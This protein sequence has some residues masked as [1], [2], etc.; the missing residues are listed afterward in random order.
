MPNPAAFAKDRKFWVR[1][2]WGSVIALISGLGTL[3]FVILMNLGLSVVWGWLDP[4][5]MEAFSGTWPILVIMT[6][7]G[8][9]VGLLHHFTNAKE[10][11]VFEAIQSGYLDPKP[12]PASLAVSLVSLIGGFSVGPEVPSGMWAGGF[13]TW[14]SERRD[15]S[16]E[17]RESNVSS[18]VVSAY[19]GLFTSP[20]AFVM[21]R[22]ELPHRQ[23][24]RFFGVLVIATVSATL[25]FA[26]FYA[27]AGDEYAD[28][29][30]LLDLPSYTLELW[31]LFVALALSVLGAA[32]A[33]V[34]GVTLGT[35]KRFAAP[36]ERR[37]ILRGAGV[38][39][40]LGLLGMALPLT[41]FLGSEGLV[42]VTEK[43]A[44]MGLAVVLAL[45]FAKILATAGALST[46]FIGGPIF[47]L[48]F[49]GGAA[50]TAINLMFP[51]IPLALAVGCT[52]AA[53]TAA[54]LPAPFMITI[55]VLLVTGI[56]ATEGIPVLLAAMVAHGIV[57]G[58]G[59]LP[60]PPAAGN[61]G[62]SSAQSTSVG[63]VPRPDSSVQ[64][65][66]D[67]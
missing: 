41:L 21:M 20:F 54:A 33:L 6:V 47:P 9:I 27:V 36:L 2:A 22:L 45:V 18:G 12:V 16:D 49:V 15:M 19:G 23:T 35:L 39:L 50:G 60:R 67:A 3:I 48:F 13:A 7:A 51:G 37:P 29:L 31:H 34:Y 56:P 26:F 38:G 57:W 58:F 17:L 24:P 61:Q 64:P 32:L 66:A 53:L 11:D 1:L 59:F 46:G 63:D 62:D 28:L 25:G 40:L 52:M 8:L 10:E 43:G 14:F 4:V 42:I 44:A 5:E 30:R 55:V 65:N